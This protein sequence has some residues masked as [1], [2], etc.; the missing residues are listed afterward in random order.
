MFI[1]INEYNYIINIYF[2]LNKS[3]FYSYN[4]NDSAIVTYK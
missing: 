1:M 2:I 3:K 4:C